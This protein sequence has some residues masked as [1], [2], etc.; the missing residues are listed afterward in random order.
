M[1][2]TQDSRWPATTISL[3]KTGDDGVHPLYRLCLAPWTCP[4][5]RVQDSSPRGSRALVVLSSFRKSCKTLQIPSNPPILAPRWA[6]SP[7]WAFF[8]Q[9]ARRTSFFIREP[10][11]ILSFIRGPPRFCF[12][13][14]RLGRQPFSPKGVPNFIGSETRQF[15]R[16]SP[17]LLFAQNPQETSTSSQEARSFFIY[18]VVCVCV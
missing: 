17:N 6:F 14:Q 4:L 3:T 1:V 15:S 5:L 2:G 16:G 8:I 13:S 12:S 10:R 11:P 9:E 18:S 7:R